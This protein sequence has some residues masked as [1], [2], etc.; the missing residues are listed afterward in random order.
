[1]SPQ[2][3]AAIGYLRAQVAKYRAELS[4]WRKKAKLAGEGLAQSMIVMPL[5][6]LIEDAAELLERLRSRQGGS[7]GCEGDEQ[8]HAEPVGGDVSG[9]A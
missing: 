4:V 3:E 7:R 1:M 2:R 9:Q 5:Q 6:D 8:G